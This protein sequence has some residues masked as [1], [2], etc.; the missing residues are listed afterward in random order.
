MDPEACELSRQLIAKLGLSDAIEI[1]CMDA[2]TYQPEENELIIC[3]SLL[4]GGDTVYQRLQNISC[5]LMV[6]D[7]EG[8]YQFL[9]KPA[10]LPKKGF[11]KIAKTIPNAKRINTTH[12]YEQS[13]E[14]AA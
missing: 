14:A 1:R 12:Y 5:S 6:R 2:L 8:A 10:Q 7:A 11:R 9:Y 4:Q 3:A 13:P